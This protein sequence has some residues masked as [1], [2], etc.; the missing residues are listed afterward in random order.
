MRKRTRALLIGV[1]AVRGLAIEGLEGVGGIR[2]DNQEGQDHQGEGSSSDPRC[3]WYSLS[4]LVHDPGD[5]LLMS[6]R[7]DRRG[8]NLGS[9]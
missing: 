7:L 3:E 8:F 2:H 4:F 9:P 1:A 5:P 6:E